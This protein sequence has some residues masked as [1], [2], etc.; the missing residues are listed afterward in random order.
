MIKLPG[1]LPLPPPPPEKKRLVQRQCRT[2]L[3]ENSA[4]FRGHEVDSTLKRH[5]RKTRQLNVRVHG[6]NTRWLDMRVLWVV[7]LTRLCSRG[8]LNGAFVGTG[9]Q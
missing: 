6:K 2:Y 1:I 7:F 5:G 9:R 8:V 3:Q 4:H